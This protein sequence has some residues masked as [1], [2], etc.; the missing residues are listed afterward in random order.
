M[1]RRHRGWTLV[2]LAVVLVVVGILAAIA[3]PSYTDQVIKSRRADGIALLYF[4]AQRQQQFFTINSS[5]TATI[6]DGGLQMTAAS[7]EGYY[8]L[9]VAAGTT[10]YT[11]TATPVSPQNADARCGS[12]TLNHLGAK[13]ISGGSGTVDDCW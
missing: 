5:F 1:R 3:Y 6:G 8:T 13:G 2:E 10:S 4:A 9:S 7:T 11:L 12:L